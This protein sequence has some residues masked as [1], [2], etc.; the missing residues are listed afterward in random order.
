MAGGMKRLAKETAIYG[1]S[2]IIGRFLNWLL[3]P[4]YTRVLVGAGEFGIYTNLY[5]WVALLLTLLTY[6]METG[7]FRFINKREEENP[8]R[9]YTT[10][11]FSIGFTSS[12]FF[13][14]TMLFLLP[15]SDALGYA[16]HPEYL[17]MML[18]VVSVD[19]FCCIPFAFLR[20][21]RRPLRFMAIKLFSIILNIVLNLFFLLAC[22]WLHTNMPGTVDWF[23]IPDYGVGY[24][25]VANVFTTAVTLLLLLPDMRP[26][27]KFRPDFGLLKKMLGYSFP[28]LILGTAG[29]LNQT[30]DK[31]LFPFLFA[32]KGYAQEQLGIYGACFKIAVVMVMFAQAFR[33]AYEPFVFARNKTDDNRTAYAEAMKYFIIFALVI[34]LGVMFYLD[35]LKYFVAPDYYPGL[36]V[37]PIVL[38]GEM[39]FGIYFNLSFWYKLTDQTK[40]GA[41]F[42]VIGF[43]IT[44]SIILVFAPT[45]GYM[46]CAWASL[47]CN[48][49]MMTLSYIFGRKRFPIPYQTGTIIVYVIGATVI[50]AAGML[51]DIDSEVLRLAW[52]SLLLVAFVA[53]IF[54]A[55]RH[56]ILGKTASN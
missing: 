49:V 14:L 28:I 40:W 36:R 24:A 11:L 34:F 47:I 17:G 41:Y 25:F 27:L 9:V 56:S 52:R 7:F 44:I 22:P 33:Y 45:F 31:I 12:V 37:V 30:A 2:S 29:I 23:Y 53:I 32:D 42:S 6:G 5:A 20:Y 38:L 35:I 50:Y 10:T 51:P 54:M 1:L 39:F 26:A 48:A 15:I 4:F 8:D 18:A 13:A 55:N 21:K 19:A 46:A 3:V 43:V 16:N